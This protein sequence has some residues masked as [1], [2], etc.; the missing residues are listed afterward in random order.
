MP[1]GPGQVR[2]GIAEA[3]RRQLLVALGG[4]FVRF[5]RAQQRLQRSRPGRGDTTLRVTRALLGPPHIADGGA[6]PRFVAGQFQVALLNLKHPLPQLFDPRA[7]P[8]EKLVPVCH[9]FMLTR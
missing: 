7:R 9:P 8:P 3:G 2:P 6:A 4:G 5:G 1:G